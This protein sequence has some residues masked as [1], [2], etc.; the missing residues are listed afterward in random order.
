MLQFMGSQ[1]VRYNLVTEQQQQ[2]ILFFFQSCAQ[3]LA[4]SPGTETVPLQWKHGVLI[5]GLPRKSLTLLAAEL[6]SYNEVILI[7][8]GPKPND[9]CPYNKRKGYT[10]KKHV[11][12]EAEVGEMWPRAKRQHSLA[13]AAAKREPPGIINTTR[14]DT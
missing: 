14:A 13:S 7:T 6:I 11:K 8:V 10:E 4:P 9:W 12:T 2:Q 5:T 1:R 3:I